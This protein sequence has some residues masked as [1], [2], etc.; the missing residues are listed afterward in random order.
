[1]DDQ[2]LRVGLCDRPL[3]LIDQPLAIAEVVWNA[4]V[5]AEKRGISTA[6]ELAERAKI[7]INTASAIMSG[8]STRVDRPTLAKLC[9][10]LE[11]TPGD[12]LLYDPSMQEAGYAAGELVPA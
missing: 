4:R 5:I 3:R 2:A 6:T 11:C 12:L 1:V 8:R 7:N 9:E 10:V